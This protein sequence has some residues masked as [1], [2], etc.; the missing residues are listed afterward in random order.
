MSF[1]TD[2][3]LWILMVICGL[4]MAQTPTV[5]R[6]NPC[7][8]FDFN[9]PSNQFGPSFIVKEFNTVMNPKPLR[10]NYH[11][12]LTNKL[13][14]YAFTQVNTA[15]TL[16]QTSL[17]ESLVYFQ[18]VGGAYFDISIRDVRTNS[19]TQI[20]HLSAFTSWQNFQ[21]HIGIPIADGRVSVACK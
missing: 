9:F 11:S 17:I 10:P 21:R 14:G 19:V 7:V 3:R 20:L 16:N 18:P 6:A 12:F 5:S 2:C 1:P 4:A 8:K 13:P 15:L